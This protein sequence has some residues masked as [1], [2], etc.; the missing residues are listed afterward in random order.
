MLN[1]VRKLIQDTQFLYPECD[2]RSDLLSNLEIVLWQRFAP[3]V[4]WPFDLQLKST[5]KLDCPPLFDWI[6]SLSIWDA[7]ESLGQIAEFAQSLMIRKSSGVYYTPPDLAYE[8]IT[9]AMHYGQFEWS[10]VRPILDPASGSG[11][12]IW[13]SAR[14]LI[15]QALQSPTPPASQ[16]AQLFVWFENFYA[17]DIDPLSLD[18]LKFGLALIWQHHFPSS[19]TPAA[20]LWCHNA[21]A[22]NS[23]LIIKQHWPGLAPGWIL[24]NPPYVGEKNNQAIFQALQQGYWKPHYRARGDLYYFFYYLALELMQAETVAAFL[25]P[26]YFYSASEAAYLRQR[27]AQETQVLEIIDYQDCKL[28]ATAPGLHSQLVFFSLA[29]SGPALATRVSRMSKL[30]TR[31]SGHSEKRQLRSQMDLFH[32]PESI[33]S[34]GESKTLEQAIQKITGQPLSEHYSINQ[35]IVT[36][37]DRLSPRWAARINQTVGTGIFV[38]SPDEAAPFLADPICSQ[39]LR[40]WF[41]NSQIQAWK[42]Q[43]QPQA[44]VI[45]SDRQTISLPAQLLQHLSPFK[46]CLAQRRE[47][48]RG[49]IAWWQLQWPRQA[50]LF[51]SPKLVLPQRA[52]RCL[53]AYT[54]NNWYASADVYFISGASE[55]DLW[56]LLA[57]LNSSLYTCWFWHQGKRKGN[58]LELYQKPLSQLPFPA[59]SGTIYQTLLDLA[60]Q[61][62]QSPTAADQQVLDQVCNDLFQLSSAEADA[63]RDFYRS[64]A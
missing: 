30:P 35:G 33:L 10:Q 15:A 52:R 47:V 13:Q 9:K 25:T 55:S 8:V 48:Q 18:V 56:V 32:G 54:D 53:A 34:W 62:Q 6:Q 46:A 20:Q 49:V 59:M 60:R 45:Y 26:S 44:Y 23:D 42:A 4:E 64:R 40:P 57:L 58:L 7:L 17:C 3:N 24:S 1:I 39:H 14:F 61:Y 5:I 38:L 28:F 36:G 50:S 37:A 27:L 11:C 29:G 22:A 31:A 2:I 43:S 21:L 19:Q 51:E 63:V 12:F 16:Q 41:K